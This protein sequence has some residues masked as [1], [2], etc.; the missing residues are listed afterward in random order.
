MDYDRGF[1]AEER[2]KLA[3]E[4]AAWRATHPLTYWLATVATL[5]FLVAVSVGAVYLQWLYDFPLR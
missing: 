2:A 3:A 1:S 5:V 4:S